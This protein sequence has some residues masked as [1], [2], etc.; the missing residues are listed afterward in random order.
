MLGVIDPEQ[1]IPANHLM[2]RTKPMAGVALQLLEPTFEGM[3]A[4]IRHP[5]IRPNG[6]LEIG[7]SRTDTSIPSQSHLFRP[8]PLTSLMTVAP[9]LGPIDRLLAPAYDHFVYYSQELRACP[10]YR[11]SLAGARTRSSRSRPK[12]SCYGF[13]P[14]G[15]HGSRIRPSH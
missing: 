6:L 10:G 8:K 14:S 1:L 7:Y 4:Q 13:A 15:P 5:S 2:L 3:Y 11:G 12:V 9:I